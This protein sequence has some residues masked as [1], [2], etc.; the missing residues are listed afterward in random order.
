MAAWVHT[1]TV[2]PA[3]AEPPTVGHRRRWTFGC[4]IASGIV[5]T[6]GYLVL[7]ALKGGGYDPL[8]HPVSSLGIGSAGWQQSLNFLVLGGLLAALALG[9]WTNLR[10]LR[11]GAVAA[12][13]C[14]LIAIGFCGAGLFTADPLNGY[15]PGTAVV[16]SERSPHGLAHDLFSTL[17]FLGFPAL[18]LVV[19]GVFRRLSRRGWARYS[20]LSAV[21]MFALF[22]LTAVALRQFGGLPAWAGLFQRLSIT[23][24]MAW[25]SITSWHWWHSTKTSAVG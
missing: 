15:P 4:G 16:S 12:V 11:R 24:A 8:R 21:V 10:P 5:F 3:A 9:Y 1:E 13:L 25:F 18:C 20:V 23:V 17:F 7:G 19:A 2:T 6:V 14:W 22:V